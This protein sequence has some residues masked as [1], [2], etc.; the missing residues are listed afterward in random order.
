VPPRRQSIKELNTLLCEG[1]ALFKKLRRE[2]AAE[3]DYFGLERILEW[4]RFG[5][6]E[7]LITHNRSVL[8]K[9]SKESK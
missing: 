2:A 3:R 6:V 5:S 8:R 7:K 9:L 1:D 4:H